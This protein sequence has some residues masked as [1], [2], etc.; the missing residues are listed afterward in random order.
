VNFIQNSKT[1]ISDPATT[2]NEREEAVASLRRLTDTGSEPAREAI[3]ELKE[4]VLPTPEFDDDEP[5]PTDPALVSFFGGKSTNRGRGG[6]FARL[7]H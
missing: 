5:A 3:Q 7:K 4:A 1:V 6:I 2:H